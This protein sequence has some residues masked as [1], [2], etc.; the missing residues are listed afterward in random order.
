MAASYDK[1]PAGLE[2]KREQ[3]VTRQS[4]KTPTIY[5]VSDGRGD[6]ARQVVKA[7]ALQFENH[8]YRV[9]VTAEVRT[10]EQVQPV[11]EQAAKTGGVVFY[12]LVAD[13]TRR[14][15]KRLAAEH[16][17]PTVDLLGPVFGALDDLFH[18]RRR[19]SPGLLYSS[20]KERFERMRAIDYTLTHDDGARPRE[21]SR[22]DVVLV[23][24]S[25]SSKSSTCFFLAYSTLR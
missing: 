15:I 4:R 9:K 14:A 5:V 12:T 6:T 18:S 2:G 19:A 7:A 1:D 16:L 11:I 3:A 25:R 24:V 10:A 23:G 21:L 17:V 13:E 20:E 22:A 8:R